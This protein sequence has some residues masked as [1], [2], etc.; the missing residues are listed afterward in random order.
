MAS[1]DPSGHTCTQ[2]PSHDPESVKTLQLYR[3]ISPGR[4]HLFASSP[5]SLAQYFV[6]NPVPHK[7]AGQ[8]KPIF[9]RGD[10]PKYCP[11]STPIARSSRTSMWNSFR[12]ELGDGVAEVLENK[13]RRK[14]RKSYERRQK[15]RRW[16]CMGETPPKKE[17]EDERE[18][19]GYVAVLKMSRGRFMG[20]TLKWELGGREYKWKGT[21]TFL[22]G[23]VKKVKGVSQDFKLVNSDNVVIATFEKDRWSVFK[24][25]E[26]YEG[27][28]NKKKSYTGTLR[29]HPSAYAT[30]DVDYTKSGPEGTREGNEKFLKNMNLEGSHAGNLTE[31]A[32]VFTCWIVVEAEHRIRY[33]V[34]DEIEEIGESFGG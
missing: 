27:T 7:H 26:K 1:L 17:L 16:F 2:L 19:A 22:P 29:I 4:K 5:S 25:S 14:E 33:K 21:R 6:V 18:V 12:I 11:S 34:L 24:P 3:R 10:N 15:F 8:W 31:E 13:R 9:Y 32:I 28:P 30:P 23:S 20:R